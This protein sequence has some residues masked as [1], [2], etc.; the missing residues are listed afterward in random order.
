MAEDRIRIVA[1]DGDDAIT[2][3]FISCGRDYVFGQ[4]TEDGTDDPYHYTYH[5]NGYMHFK[6]RASAPDPD[7]RPHFYGPSLEN[8]RGFVSTG[9]TPVFKEVGRVVSPD[10]RDDDRGF[11]NI[12]YIDVRNAEHGMQ[13]Q[14]FICEPG[15]PIARRIEH[16]NSNTDENTDIR[17]KL[18]Y[19]IYTEVEPWVGVAHWQQA[20]GTHGL[21]A[22]SNFRPMGSS[23]DVKENEDPYPE[24]C[25]NGEL[26]CDG[27]NGT[28]PLCMECYELT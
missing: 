27:P 6:W 17:P 11:D 24:P 18:T 15:F 21:G 8:F 28:G 4:V 5:K 10:F 7:I 9:L 12:T 1:T 23:V 26:G 22:T 19:Q 20:S 2:L 25:P 13:Y 16:I 14:S 3:G